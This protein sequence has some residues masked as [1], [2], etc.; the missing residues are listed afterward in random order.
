MGRN[1]V[2]KIGNGGR[3]ITASGM[4]HSL[5]TKAV[6]TAARDGCTQTTS[7][8][9]SGVGK[10]TG[11]AVLGLGNGRVLHTTQQQM[12]APKTARQGAGQWNA[13]VRAQCTHVPTCKCNHFSTSGST[14]MSQAASCH[15]A[16][17]TTREVR[18][19]SV[20][21]AHKP[22]PNDNLDSS[23]Q[24]AHSRKRRRIIQLTAL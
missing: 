7:A 14:L 11:A 21:T 6:C 9:R 1:R 10:E 17:V 23:L 18:R 15:V 16:P 3:C 12:P 13:A 22:S 19:S 4:P 8:G 20:A 24:H 2:G 5:T